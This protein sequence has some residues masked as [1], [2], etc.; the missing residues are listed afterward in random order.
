MTPPYYIENVGVGLTIAAPVADPV[1]GHFIGVASI[2]YSYQKLLREFAS[3]EFPISFLV[4]P[5]VYFD[6]GD[7]IVGLNKSSSERRSF[8]VDELFQYSG[9]MSFERL[10]FENEV[11]AKMKSGH[12]GTDR[13]SR[14]RQDGK[15][16][17]LFIAYAPVNLTILS[18][19]D[20]S[21]LKNGVN[22]T[23]FTMY[24]VAV[25]NYDVEV[26]RP[27]T[28]IEDSMAKG[29][30]RLVVIGAVVIAFL[31][32]VFF[33][34]VCKVR[35]MAKPMYFKACLPQFVCCEGDRVRNK[36]HDRTIECGAE[37]QFK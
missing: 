1:S 9:N 14:R 10:H 21:S 17:D 33:G 18:P 19:L 32:I 27:F 24:S 11:L 20:L 4:T 28:K 30:H 12:S 15:H 2:D 26:R 16:E 7:T 35:S 22:V 8:I 23:T 29:I 36:T 31:S 6:S 34:L 3:L 25:V 5:E 37:H 13:F